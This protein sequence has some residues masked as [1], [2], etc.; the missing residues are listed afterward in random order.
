MIPTRKRLL[1]DIFLSHSLSKSLA[2]FEFSS[3]NF[4]PW[5]PSISCTRH[6]ILFPVIN[7]YDRIPSKNLAWSVAD[8]TSNQRSWSTQ[9]DYVSITWPPSAWGHLTWFRR[10]WF[11]RRSTSGSWKVKYQL[12]VYTKTVDSVERARWLASQTLNI[13]CY[14]PPRNSG[15]NGVPVCIRDKWRNH[16]NYF[17]WCILSH[18]FSIY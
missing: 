2:L 11:I 1:V 3:V 4:E 17:L 10:T 14:L 16:P 12:L 6:P 15:K 13:L 9:Y 7:K 8:F 18:C 5:L